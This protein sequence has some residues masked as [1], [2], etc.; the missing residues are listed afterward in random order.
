MV[1]LGDP[2]QGGQLDGFLVVP[3]RTTADQFGF[4][5]TV[6]RLTAKALS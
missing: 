4:L 5:Q 6:D 3:G 2:L 1:E